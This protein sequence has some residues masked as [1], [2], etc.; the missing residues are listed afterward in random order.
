M[1]A[2]AAAQAQERF[3]PRDLPAC[4]A[5]KPQDGYGQPCKQPLSPL[6]AARELD[7]LKKANFTFAVEGDS[8]VVSLRMA[9]A[10]LSYP[11]GPRL[12]CEIQGY[13]DRI[14]DDIYG[15]RFRWNRMAQAM[16]DLNLMDI[17]YQRVAHARIN[18]SPGYAMAASPDR[19]ALE[20]AGTEVADLAVDGGTLLGPRTVTVVKGTACRKSLSGCTMIY[21]ADGDSA[22]DFASNALV[23]QVDMRR[24]VIVGIHNARK[25]GDI[26]AIN[27]RI[28]ELLRGTDVPRYEAFMRF[29]TGDVLRQVEGGE[30][31][32]RRI[33]AGYSNGGVWAVDALLANP[34]V[35]AGAISMSPGIPALRAAPPLPGQRVFLGAG[36]MEPPFHRAT[37]AIAQALKERGIKVEETYVPSGHSMNTWINLW[38]NAINALNEQ[39]G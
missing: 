29:V 37:L 5:D 26:D 25:T 23:K 18:G 7:K 32:L 3:I 9:A 11:Q 31:P 21:L 34:A 17:R 15:A 6:E 1:N 2:G 28:G 36:H 13:L 20:R 39:P 33:A 14:G 22:V 38:N 10:D 8:L 4:A 30:T 24:F 27:T 19:A 35:F 16:L 12:C